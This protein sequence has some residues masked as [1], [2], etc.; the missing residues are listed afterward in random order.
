MLTNAKQIV[1]AAVVVVVVIIVRNMPLLDHFSTDYYMH[2]IH[3]NYHIYFPNFKEVVGEFLFPYKF[4]TF[5]S[6]K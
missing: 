4:F 6:D 5:T 3:N 2:K 1:A